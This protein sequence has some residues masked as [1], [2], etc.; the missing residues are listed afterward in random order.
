MQLDI[1][2]GDFFSD[3]LYAA[4]EQ[5]GPRLTTLNLVHIEELD[6]RAISLLSQFCSNLKTL[7]FYN[8][9]F[10]ENGVRQ[11]DAFMFIDRL[12]RRDEENMIQSL[13]WL[14]VEKLNIT[15]E[16]SPKFEYGVYQVT[17][18]QFR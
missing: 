2:G 7:G 8:C 15:S 5:L 1:W 6:K 13:S 14:D 17:R 4:L 18:I 16:V 10:Q 3:E 11:D 9:G 12:Q